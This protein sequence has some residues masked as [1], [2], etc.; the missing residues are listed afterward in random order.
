MNTEEYENGKELHKSVLLNESLEILNIVAGDIYLDATLGGGGHSAEVWKRF[1]TK[2][3]IAGIDADSEAVEIARSRLSIEGAQ[4]KFTVLNFRHIDKVPELLNLGQPSK[5][6]FDLGWNKM[7][8]E[9]EEGKVGRGF[10]FQHDEPL[11]MTFASESSDAP[12]T[13]RTIV[14]EWEEE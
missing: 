2:V 13:A 10:S 1:G 6:L 11:V 3:V 7:Q 5:I 12:F 8:F 9:T 4:P 14:N